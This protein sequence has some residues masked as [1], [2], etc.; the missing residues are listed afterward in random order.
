MN[1]KTFLLCY[2]LTLLTLIEPIYASPLLE[3]ST[4]IITTS[5][6]SNTTS[7]P[8]SSNSTITILPP[9]PS[10]VSP[11]AD[12][13]G[14][15]GGGRSL[16][17]TF[18]QCNTTCTFW[19][20]CINSHMHRNCTCAAQS[21]I[22][23]SVPCT[24]FRPKKRNIT[25]QIIQF[26]TPPL[27]EQEITTD[28]I[29]QSKQEEVVEPI[30]PEAPPPVKEEFIPPPIE[31]SRWKDQLSSLFKNGKFWILAVFLAL[32]TI[33]VTNWYKQKEEIPE[34]KPEIILPER[35][36]PLYLTIKKYLKLKITQQKITSLALQN[37]WKQEEI[38]LVFKKIQQEGFVAFSGLKSECRLRDFYKGDK[39]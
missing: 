30:V 21:F 2:M 22:V 37:G 29:I 26:P 11:Q 18:K 13:R 3:G 19:S 9:P 15:G 1:R 14:G 32:G 39:L 23:Q 12:S 7:P 16:Y 36:Y 38:S 25:E 20:G 5:L 34:Q 27:K 6:S 4:T 31:E 8:N 24:D 35:I 10:S 28:T 17:T 33:W